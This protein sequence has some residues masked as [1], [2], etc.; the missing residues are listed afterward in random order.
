MKQISA[1]IKHEFNLELKQ[2]YFISSI[3]LYL[4]STVFVCYLSFE[5][6]EES[7]IWNGLFWIVILFS[8]TN[9]ISKSFLNENSSKQLFIYTIINPRHLIIGKIVYNLILSIFLVTFSFIIFNILIETEKTN[10]NPQLFIVGCILGS[11]SISSILTMISAIAAKTNNN[12]GILAIL[13]FPIILP[14]ILLSIQVTSLSF[15]GGEFNQAIDTL[16][17]LGALNIL[18]I[19]L[20]FLLFPYLWRE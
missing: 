17:I 13:A 3:L 1:I 5:K 12:I 2:K 10:F 16:V 8:L 14:S 19:A 18:S 7:T 9:A 4:V 11:M 6:I 15:I 20:A